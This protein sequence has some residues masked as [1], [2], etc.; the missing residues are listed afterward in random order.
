MGDVLC[1]ALATARAPPRAIVAS[2][3]CAEP[4]TAWPRMTYRFESHWSPDGLQ[5]RDR[6]TGEI[7]TVGPGEPRGEAERATV[8]AGPLP[9]PGSVDAGRAVGAPRREPQPSPRACSGSRVGCWPRTRGCG[10]RPHGVAPSG[11]RR[12]PWS[13]CSR[14]SS[15]RCPP[16]G[17]VLVSHLYGPPLR[18]SGT[19][20]R[21]RRGPRRPRTGPLRLARA[22]G[23]G[24]RLWGRGL[25]VR[26]R[27]PGAGL[28]GG[29][30][31]GPA[32]PSP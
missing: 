13:V 17:Q 22:R 16:A 2:R 29:L 12:S 31:P 15:P 23:V 1:G 5:V 8:E 21:R 24:V 26:A 32:G 18:R 30:G 10:L 4:P 11:P 14:W 6:Q 28:D 3:R 20:P 27:A 19:P 9:P 25:A 7:R